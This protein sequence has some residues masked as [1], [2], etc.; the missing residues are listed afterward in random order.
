MQPYNINSY[1][2]LLKYI[3]WS[4]RGWLRYNEFATCKEG[5][6]KRQ[7]RTR[8]GD[9]VK[10]IPWR[11]LKF[12]E[13][14]LR[15]SIVGLNGKVKLIAATSLL[16]STMLM[17]KPGPGLDSSEHG[18]RFDACSIWKAVLSPPELFKE[19][20]ICIERFTECQTLDNSQLTF[21]LQSTVSVLQ[22]RVPTGVNKT[23]TKT[24]SYA[25]KL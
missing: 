13:N 5:K 17:K 1:K 19:C 25:P 12:M 23:V 14:V 18:A 21:Q 15:K 11:N 3:G 8:A 16:K 24:V 22:N 10:L 20:T 7:V 4:V 2:L 9:D 6:D